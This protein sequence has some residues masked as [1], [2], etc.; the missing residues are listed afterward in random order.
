MKETPAAAAQKALS[1]T[2]LK[3]VLGG[4]LKNNYKPKEQGD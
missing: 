2:A 1:F 4:D 3:S